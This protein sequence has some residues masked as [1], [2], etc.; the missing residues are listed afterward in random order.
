VGLRAR[1]TPSFLPVLALLLA[2]LPQPRAAAKESE[3]EDKN[4]LRDQLTEREDKNRVEHPWTY[5]L[6]ENPLTATGEYEITLEDTDPIDSG[7]AKE[8]RLRLEQQLEGELFYTLGEPL[9]FFVQGSVHFDRDLLRETP[10]RVD[11]WYVER[12][13]MWV[14]A[15]DL[16]E[17][18]V[19][20]DVGRLQ[21]EDDRR[22]WWDEE[23]D[24]VRLAWEGGPGDAFGVEVALASELG[25]NRSDR[26]H[27][28]ADDQDR[29]RVLGSLSWD[30]APN[31]GFELFALYEADRSGHAPLG[32]SIAPSHEDKSDAHLFWLGPRVLGAFSSESSWI[33]GYWIDSGWVQGRDLTTEYGDPDAA[34][35]LPVEAVLRREVSGWALDLG[36]LAIAAVPLQPRVTLTYAVGSGDGGGGSHD[37]AYRQSDIQANETSFGGVRRFPHY[38]RL[39]DPELSNIAIATAGAGISLFRSSSLDVVY[40]YYRLIHRA[41]SLRNSNSSFD[42]VF[43]GRHRDVGHAIDVELAI[44]EGDR[45]EFEL[46]GSVLRAGSAFGPRSGDWAFGTL[47]ALRIAF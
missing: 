45:F 18:G 44:E 17:S 32:A 5:S 8:D 35:R 7:P 23:L 28:D 43:D 47:A 42:T 21:F 4:D 34:G 9:S 27:L 41:D 36:L 30:I 22:W 29:L 13:E 25:P 37:H 6:F 15:G 31:H 39:L 11:D 16:F 40:H 14:F 3:E 26:S 33:L 12:G 24:A 1:S 10:D 19:D 20:L 46:S 2:V 38:G